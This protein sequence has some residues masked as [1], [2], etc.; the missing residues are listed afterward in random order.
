[1]VIPNLTLIYDRKK[2]AAK[3]KAAVVELRISAGKVRKYISTGVKLLPKEWKNGS[4]TNRED[5]ITLNRQLQ[6]LVK[7]CSEII[8]QMMEEDNVDLDAIPNILK[9]RLSQKQTFLEYAKECASQKMKSL[10]VGTQKRYKVVFDFLEDWKG[11]VSFADVTEKNIAKMDKYLEDRGLKESSRYNYHKILK[12]FVI[13]AFDDGLIAKNPYS[14]MKI[15]RGEEDGLTRFLTPAEFHRFETCKIESEHLERVRDLFVFQTYTAMSY[16]DLAQF[17]YRLCEKMDGQMVYRS[18]RVKTEQLF[19]I[20]LLQPALAILQK[21]NYKLPIIS[22]VKY[23]DY[24]KS[25]VTYAK[26]DKKVTTHWARHTGATMLVNEGK[27]PMHI[28]QHILGHASIR[29]TEKT[30]AKVLDRTIVESMA[31][32]QNDSLLSKGGRKK[33]KKVG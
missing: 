6:S 32:Y 17:D 19:T 8:T 25:A 29:E 1:M 15:K 10:K 33:K 2:Q 5:M 12:S 27:V 28:V 9:D 13:Q 18:S 3:D 14:K 11:I 26:I 21:Y 31:N 4:V 30:Y 24:L 7:K 16:S 23:N 20:V 22:N